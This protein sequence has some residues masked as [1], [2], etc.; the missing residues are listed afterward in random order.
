MKRWPHLVALGSLIC[1]ACGDPGEA[2]F[3]RSAEIDTNNASSAAWISDAFRRNDAGAFHVDH[4]GSVGVI[5]TVRIDDSESI[6]GR[7]FR[8]DLALDLEGDT[9]GA[10]VV[11]DEQVHDCEDCNG[12]GGIIGDALFGPRQ[13]WRSERGTINLQYD[14]DE[15]VTHVDIAVDMVADGDNLL[16]ENTAEGAFTL[17]GSVR[18][19]ELGND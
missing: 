14:A 8:S 7:T 18:L 15:E 6:C 2:R 11:Y 17:T 1:A 9:C 16:S 13:Q 10:H 4:G 12:L 19:T 3:E 5:V